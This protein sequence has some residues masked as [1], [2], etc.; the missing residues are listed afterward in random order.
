M[1]SSTSGAPV[2]QADPESAGAG[3]DQN[4]LEHR[5]EFLDVRAHHDHVPGL[6]GRIGGEDVQ[7]S[8]PQHLDLPGPAVTGVN[9]H[10]PVPLA[11]RPRLQGSVVGG[12]R[13]LQALQ[14]RVSPVTESGVVAVLG[15]LG[16]CQRR[17]QLT[18]VR[19]P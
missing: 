13:Q 2:S 14:Q 6:D 9:L 15:G 18:G 10:R 1:K 7:E 11:E 16:R 17:L 3:V 5:G 8:V 4:G 19:A 12:D